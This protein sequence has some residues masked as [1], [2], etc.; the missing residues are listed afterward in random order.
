MSS[1]KPKIFGQIIAVYI[2]SSILSSNVESSYGYLNQNKINQQIQQTSINLNISDLETDNVL[3]IVKVNNLKYGRLN[4]EVKL[5]GEKIKLIN[6]N[7]TEI[8]LS[9]LL[10]QG[11]NVVEIC[12]SYT[13][14]NSSI[15][16]EFSG[17]NTLVSQSASG[18]GKLNQR[19]IIRIK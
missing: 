2:L 16:I 1:F 18:T 13:P 3:K 4:G 12:G 15:K 19:L 8:N 14:I 5:N 11:I 17:F 7:S 10:K 9:S 6:S